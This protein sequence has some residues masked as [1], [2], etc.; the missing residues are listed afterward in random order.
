MLN[1]G[2]KTA[3]TNFG[4]TSHGQVVEEVALH[5]LQ[6]LVVAMAGVVAKQQLA[7]WS[8][9]ILGRVFVFKHSTMETTSSP[10]F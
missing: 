4:F 10:G 2:W 9:C 8:E 7:D 3:N 1:W 5:L 6:R